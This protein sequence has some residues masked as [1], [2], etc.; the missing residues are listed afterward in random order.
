MGQAKLAS[1]VPEL[2][3]ADVARRFAELR[4]K[5]FKTGARE[6]DL[7]EFR[8]LL[9]EHPTHELWDALNDPM[10]AAE[11]VILDTA[12]GWGVGAG[13]AAVWRHKLRGL[14]EGLGYDSAPVLERLL[15][16]NISVCWLRLS[17]AEAALSSAMK[18]AYNLKN[19]AQLDESLA[20]AQKRFT[21]ACEALARVRKLKLPAV[22][23]NVAAEGGKQVNLA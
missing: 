12:Q 8:R 22:Q 16:K 7:K 20:A 15:I 10:D 21:R 5:V 2:S 4:P 9:R 14:R 19:V 17:L 11:T 23:I 18:G 1:A 13:V 6:A 3:P